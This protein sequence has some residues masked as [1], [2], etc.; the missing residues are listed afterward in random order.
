MYKRRSLPYIRN[1][2]WMKIFCLT[3]FV[4]VVVVVGF[5]QGGKVPK[6]I[7]VLL[8]P[9]ESMVSVYFCCAL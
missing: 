1:T 9:L 4:V 5:D 3:V 7:L 2:A 8:V 6:E